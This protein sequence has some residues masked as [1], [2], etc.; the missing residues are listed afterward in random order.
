VSACCSTGR[1][2]TSRASAG[3]PRDDAAVG[4]GG[5]HVLL[6]GDND[7]NSRSCI[8]SS[9]SSSTNSGDVSKPAAGGDGS[10]SAAAGR[11]AHGGRGEEPAGVT[12][13][14][15]S[16]RVNRLMSLQDFVS[17]ELL[18]VRFVSLAPPRLPDP[19]GRRRRRRRL[20][21]GR[22]TSDTAKAKCCA[23]NQRAADGL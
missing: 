14:G 3:R 6:Q 8:R 10:G 2:C 4:I 23:E 5:G 7:N 22:P 15:S 21:S 16:G 11:R 17:L 13:S 9:S 20:A 12:S 18:A 1:R 19:S